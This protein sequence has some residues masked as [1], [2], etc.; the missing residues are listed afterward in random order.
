M[1]IFRKLFRQKNYAGTAP[2]LPKREA[3]NPPEWLEPILMDARNL[4]IPDSDQLDHAFNGFLDSLHA[5]IEKIE[6]QISGQIFE[7]R[8]IVQRT[9]EIAPD[10]FE[11]SLKR[12]PLDTGHY[13]D[14]GKDE[15]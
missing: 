1:G 7:G 12:Y 6:A 2:P 4:E 3:D 13:I 5:P 8:E 15:R 9:L 11:K 10:F 14:G